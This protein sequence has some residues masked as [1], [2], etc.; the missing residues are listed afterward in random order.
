MEN[1]Y[2]RSVLHAVGRS[3]HQPC[4]GG[5]E[6][7]Y[8]VHHSFSHWNV[9]E[10]SIASGR[11]MKVFASP[12]IKHL[13]V[14][15][16]LNRSSISGTYIARIFPQTAPLLAHACELESG[17]PFST[18]MQPVPGHTDWEAEPGLVVRPHSYA[19]RLS[20]CIP[21]YLCLFQVKR[22][23]SFLFGV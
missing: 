6:G 1:I 13:F 21:G 14:E 12:C 16:V 20:G 17:T 2:L 18:Q 4:P 5:W 7:A 8:N 3:F 19:P 23:S 22:D 10:W 9:G 11:N 15:S